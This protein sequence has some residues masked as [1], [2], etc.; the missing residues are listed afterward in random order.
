MPPFSEDTIVDRYTP[1]PRRIVVDDTPP[2]AA[3]T[4]DVLY[5]SPRRPITPNNSDW[6]PCP[7]PLFS[8]QQQTQQK[9]VS[10]N[11]E[12]NEIHEVLHLLDYS[13][14]EIRSTWLSLEDLKESKRNSKRVIQQ[15]KKGAEGCY[16]RGLEAKSSQQAKLKR[17]QNKS[18]VR[19]VV[20]TEQ[21]KQ[22]YATGTIDQ[23]KIA[24]VS[25]HC[26]EHCRVNATK[27]GLRDEQEAISLIL[28]GYETIEESHCGYN[29]TGL[30]LLT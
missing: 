27:M 22:R 23:D 1:H 20:M 25:L 15:W 7:A 2:V 13:H 29:C 28:E 19:F 24:N 3:T 26:T 30:L 16:L 21:S 10:I 5:R 6:S 17:K 8:Q 14:H 9:R 11:L 18:N 4:S 12:E